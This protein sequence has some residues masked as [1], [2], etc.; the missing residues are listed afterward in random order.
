MKFCPLRPR[1][2]RPGCST[3]AVNFNLLRKVVVALP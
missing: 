3:V 1:L 2:Y